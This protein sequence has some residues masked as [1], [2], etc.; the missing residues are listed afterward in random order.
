MHCLTQEKRPHM[1]QMTDGF[2]DNV[3]ANSI[4]YINLSSMQGTCSNVCLVLST[5]TPKLYPTPLIVSAYD[6][7]L[8]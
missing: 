6:S 3:I 4:M 2:V 5:L 7:T 1:N 8:F